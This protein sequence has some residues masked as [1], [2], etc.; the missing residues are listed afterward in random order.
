[1][2]ERHEIEFLYQ[3]LDHVNVRGEDHKMT[4]IT[5]MHK[6]RAILLATVLP[7]PSE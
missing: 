7:D 1:M 5:I 6:L 2:L 4:V 3:L